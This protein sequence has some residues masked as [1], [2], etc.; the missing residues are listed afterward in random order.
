MANNTAIAYTG[1]NVVN[2]G[3]TLTASSTTFNIPATG[4]YKISFGLVTNATNAIFAL[5]ITGTDS[6]Y[7]ETNAT[8]VATWIGI[9]LDLSFSANDTLQIINR[10]GSSVNVG[11]GLTVGTAGS[12]GAYVEIQRIQ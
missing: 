5:N 6:F 2:N 12:I 11:R 9:V 7:I 10:S 3:I 8:N 1:G 4:V